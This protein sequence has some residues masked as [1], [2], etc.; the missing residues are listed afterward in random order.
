MSGFWLQQQ[1]L[2]PTAVALSAPQHCSGRNLL[3]L[4]RLMEDRVTKHS[5]TQP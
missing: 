3:K 1:L 4:Q 2:V 5:S